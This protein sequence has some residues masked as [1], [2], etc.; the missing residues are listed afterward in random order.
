[1]PDQI[2]IRDLTLEM[3]AG[4]YDH[5][6]ENKQRVIVN[7][8][9]DVEKNT[10]PQGI[11]DVVSYEDIANEIIN[12]SVQKHY[13]LL[14]E[15]AENIARACLNVPLVQTASIQL[16]KPDIIENTKSVGVKINRP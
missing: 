5:E 3:S 11:D 16:E 1:M 10:N 12:L 4:I 8:V 15:F 9:L 13:D 6:K 7:V 14:E 2:F